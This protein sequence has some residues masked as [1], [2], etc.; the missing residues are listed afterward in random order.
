MNWVV[1]GSWY[2]YPVFFKQLLT[3]KLDVDIFE[4]PVSHSPIE[5]RRLTQ[6]S[7]RGVLTAH[8][9]SHTLTILQ[10]TFSRT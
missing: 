7:S 3:I 4:R 8:A 2:G 5:L 10:L 6:P 1:I 9:F